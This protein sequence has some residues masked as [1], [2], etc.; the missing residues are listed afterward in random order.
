MTRET[1]FCETPARRATSV[2]TGFN[3][4]RSASRSMSISCFDYAVIQMM[5]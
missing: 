4:E 1:V 5:T 3:I 2:I